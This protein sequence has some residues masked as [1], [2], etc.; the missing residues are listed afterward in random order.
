M[1]WFHAQEHADACHCWTEV[2]RCPASHMI[3]CLLVMDDN[4]AARG[5]ESEIGFIRKLSV[6]Y[7]CRRTVIAGEAQDSIADSMAVDTD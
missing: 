2:R 6:R 5:F 7:K 1:R 4:L 3:G